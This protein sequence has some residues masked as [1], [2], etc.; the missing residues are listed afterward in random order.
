MS[1]WSG[2]SK[3]SILRVTHYRKAETM[4][5]LDVLKGMQNGPRGAPTGAPSSGGGPS[6]MTMGLLG[7]LA[8]KAWKSYSGG[9]AATVPQ[10]GSQPSGG[11]L[12][13]D[14]PLGGLLGSIFGGN[15][16]GGGRANLAGGAPGSTGLG[17]LL[18]SALAGGAM[19]GLLQNGL[20]QLT[21]DMHSN[22]AG[23]QAK[24]WVGTGPNED[25]STGD[26]AKAVGSEDLDRLIQHTG[27]S[28][29]ELLS[30]LQS[31]LPGAVDELTP[32]GRI[33]DADELSRMI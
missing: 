33:P 22:G 6:M 13:G 14:G 32:D 9:A 2:P 12:G 3:Y 11:P 31:E 21:Q 19:G 5:I 18:T 17:G 20:R 29:S 28:R 23:D 25:I 15:S 27:M 10:P 24:S 8:Y 1:A 4:G 30:G 26:L 16:S 7:L